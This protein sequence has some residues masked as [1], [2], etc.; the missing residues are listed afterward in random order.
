[1]SRRRW[2][3]LKSVPPQAQNKLDAIAQEVLDTHGK[4]AFQSAIHYPIEDIR[5]NLHWTLESLL[6]SDYWAYRQ[7]HSRLH[8]GTT[9]E[10]CGS[11]QDTSLYHLHYG[12]MGHE[13]NADVIVLCHLCRDYY[14]QQLR[15]G[16]RYGGQVQE[17]KSWLWIP[18]GHKSKKNLDTRAI[19]PTTPNPSKHG[20]VSLHT[21]FL[22][23]PII[24]A[25]KKSGVVFDGETIVQIYDIDGGELL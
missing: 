21:S 3:F 22:D 13:G 15:V 20:G 10:G 8:K 12:E 17:L 1:M 18:K 14:K 7:A 16:R 11:V 2:D 24:T 19:K 4:F 5:G 6:E 23:K 9:C 25:N